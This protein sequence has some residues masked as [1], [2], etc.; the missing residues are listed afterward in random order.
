MGSVSLEIGHEAA[1]QKL[2]IP[3]KAGI[4]YA[5]ASAIEPQRLW[6]TGSPVGA[7]LLVQQELDHAGH[8]SFAFAGE[9]RLQLAGDGI[10]LRGLDRNSA[11]DMPFTVSM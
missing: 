3:A 6:N 4:Q 7:E 2:V 9:H 10:R 1:P 5:A 11:N 8:Q